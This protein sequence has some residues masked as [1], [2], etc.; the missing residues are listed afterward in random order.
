LGLVES[1]H[2]FFA[3]AFASEAKSIREALYNLKGILGSIAH[4]VE[5][6]PKRMLGSVR[7]G[8]VGRIGFAG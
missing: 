7:T 8:V 4:P 5:A 6:N 3:K 2:F 1:F